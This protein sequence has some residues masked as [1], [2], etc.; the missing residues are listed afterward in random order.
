MIYVAAGGGGVIG[1][2]SSA[3]RAPQHP[4]LRHPPTLTPHDNLTTSPLSHQTPPPQP[5][6]PT[7]TA[8]HT[9][10]STMPSAAPKASFKIPT[11]KKLRKSMPI[12]ATTARSPERTAHPLAGLSGLTEA[13]CIAFHTT[14]GH[15]NANIC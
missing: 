8:P 10:P 3:L 11:R 13:G 5:P 7:P 14:T 15:L 4:P 2:L 9:T 12:G 1:L 6:A